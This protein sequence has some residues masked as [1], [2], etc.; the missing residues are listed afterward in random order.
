MKICIAVGLMMGSL[1]TLACGSETASQ[2]LPNIEATVQ[3]R[4]AEDSSVQDLIEARAQVIADEM[5]SDLT[6]TTTESISSVP[7]PPTVIEIEVEK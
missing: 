5:I 7:T 1:L 2:T 4:I 3:A 6:P